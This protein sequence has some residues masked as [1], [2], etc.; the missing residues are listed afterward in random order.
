[1]NNLEIKQQIT[2]SLE[3]LSSEHLAIVAKFINFLTNKQAQENTSTQNNSLEEFPIDTTSI[4]GS[5]PTLRNSTLGDLLE[6][7]GTW[8]GDDIRECLQLVHE[9]RTP[10][11]F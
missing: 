10:L 7:A 6:F 9:T 2:Q 3:Q 11:E 8:E 5:T 1:M 4:T